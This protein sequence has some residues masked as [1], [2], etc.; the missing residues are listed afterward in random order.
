MTVEPIKMTPDPSLSGFVFPTPSVIS[1]R[2]LS[3]A[4]CI[5]RYSIQ[6]RFWSLDF[7]HSDFRS[8]LPLAS[9]TY[10]ALFVSSSWESR[11]GDLKN[12]K[13][14]VGCTDDAAGACCSSWLFIW[15]IW[16]IWLSGY[17]Y[18]EGDYCSGKWSGNI[19]VVE[20]RGSIAL[21]SRPSGSSGRSTPRFPTSSIRSKRQ[22]LLKQGGAMPPSSAPPAINLLLS[23]GCIR[24]GGCWDDQEWR[25]Y[26]RWFFTH[27]A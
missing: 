20:L 8:V 6:A 13:C 17:L 16:E 22:C 4:Q 24:L 2:E 15:R 10:G 1:A 3:K 23:V 9:F 12:C 5:R 27:M 19:R 11:I 7:S 25:K 21:S 14:V 26:W 18:H